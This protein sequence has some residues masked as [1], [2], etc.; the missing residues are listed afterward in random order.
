MLSPYRWEKFSLW[1]EDPQDILTFLDYHFDSATRG[2][3]KQNEPIQ[4]PLQ[5]LA[6]ASVV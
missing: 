2:V 5:A 1:V 3:H 6:S 4:S